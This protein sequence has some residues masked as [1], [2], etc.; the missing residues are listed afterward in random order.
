MALPSPTLHTD[1]LRLRP[2]EDSDADDLFALH[3][4]AAVLRYWDSP[5]WTDPARAEKF[6]AASRQQAL[7]GTGARL[8]AG[9]AEA[10]LLRVTATAAPYRRP[11][12]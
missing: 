9:A 12:G 7:D 2:F 11:T 3:S 1:R 4:N 10:G 5:P 6:I 8:T